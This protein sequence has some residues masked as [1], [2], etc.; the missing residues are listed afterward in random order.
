M[1][2]VDLIVNVWERSYRNIL[3]RGYF[4]AIEESNHHEFRKVL[5][6]N[7]VAD[8]SSVLKSADELTKAGE[9]DEYFVVEKELTKALKRSTYL[10]MIWDEFSITVM[11]LSL[12]LH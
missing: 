2:E 9:L 6:I 7:D 8:L 1:S 3:R 11:H 10:C 5:L 4:T 12:Q